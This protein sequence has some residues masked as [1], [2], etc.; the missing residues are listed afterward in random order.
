MREASSRPVRVTVLRLEVTGGTIGHACHSFIARRD[1]EHDASAVWT[2]KLQRDC[3][4]FLRASTPILRCI[5][6]PLIHPSGSNGLLEDCFPNCSASSN[7][8]GGP[9]PD[10]SERQGR[11]GKVP[12]QKW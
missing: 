5:S 10:R 12:C 3:T 2:A 11:R 4:G 1:I 6:I 8:A 7:T 9:L